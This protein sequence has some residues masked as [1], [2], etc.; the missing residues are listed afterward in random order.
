MTAILTKQNARDKALIGG[1]STPTTNGEFETLRVKGNA[2][3][4]GKIEN[5]QINKNGLQMEIY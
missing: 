5:E 3:I 2:T 4:D 1:N